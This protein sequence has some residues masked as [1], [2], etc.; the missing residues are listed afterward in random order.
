MLFHG[1]RQVI[2]IKRRRTDRKTGKTTIT[3]VYAVTSLTAEHAA[4]R[5]P[6][7]YAAIGPSRPTTTSGTPAFEQL[8]LIWP[9]VQQKQYSAAYALKTVRN[10]CP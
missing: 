2:Q 9:E 6:R 1:A 4:P 10:L 3:T 8:H 7:R 5:S